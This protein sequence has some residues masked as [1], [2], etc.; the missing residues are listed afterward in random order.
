M[1]HPRRRRRQLSLLDHFFWTITV[2]VT[3]MT[4]VLTLAYAAQT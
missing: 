1:S 3:V 4:V 2:S